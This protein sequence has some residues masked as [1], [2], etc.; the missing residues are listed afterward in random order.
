MAAYAGFYYKP[1]TT[2]TT[3]TT[4]PQTPSELSPAQSGGGMGG[5]GGGRASYQMQ[6]QLGVSDYDAATPCSSPPPPAHTFE[7]EGDN[8][9]TRA[10][11]DPAGFQAPGQEQLEARPPQTK[12]QQQY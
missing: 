1:E 10:A 2:G 8:S 9:S 5:G 3:M 6:Q 7:M 11:V 4:G 12:Q